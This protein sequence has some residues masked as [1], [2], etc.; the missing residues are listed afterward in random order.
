VDL[1]GAD[2]AEVARWRPD[3]IGGSVRLLHRQ[4]QGQKPDQFF[5]RN[6]QVIHS[7]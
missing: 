6:V 1:A 7:L 4:P 5:T 2:F 3:V